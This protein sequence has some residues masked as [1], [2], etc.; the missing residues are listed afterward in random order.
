MTTLNDAKYEK[1]ITKVPAGTINDM[2][3][4]YLKSLGATS[5]DLHSAWLEIAGSGSTY[6][7]ARYNYFAANGGTGNDL[8]ELELTFW[9][10]LV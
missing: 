1:L 3:L 4:A 8:N 10:N 9:Q 6:N 2:E 7:D 5:N